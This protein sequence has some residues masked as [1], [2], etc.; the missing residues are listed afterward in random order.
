MEKANANVLRVQ[1]MEDGLVPENG[2]NCVE[3]RGVGGRT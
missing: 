3:L 1:V 2:E